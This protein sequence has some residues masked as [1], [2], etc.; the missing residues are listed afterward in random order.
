M[1]SAAKLE[2]ETNGTGASFPVHLPDLETVFRDLLGLAN[3]VVNSDATGED[4]LPPRLSFDVSVDGYHYTVW[5]VQ[6]EREPGEPRPQLSPREWEI[7]NL[8]SK[9]LPTK[10]IASALSLRPCTVST[11]T[12]RIYLKL[13]VN[14]RAEMVAKILN[15]N[16]LFAPPRQ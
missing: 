4:S 9:G 14:S 15:A 10:A 13:N 12:K 16:L 6:S 1:F 5:I 11:Y 7:A 2:T 3:S 8:I